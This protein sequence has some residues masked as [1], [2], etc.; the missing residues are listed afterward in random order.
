M[1]HERIRLLDSFRSL[2]ILSVMFYHFTFRWDQVLP[3]GNFYGNLGEYGWVG[4]QFFF[5]ISGFVISYTLENTPSPGR[6]FANRFIR[7][8]PPLLL[9]SLITFSVIRIFDNVPLFPLAHQPADLLPSLTLIGPPVFNHFTGSG[10]VFSWVDESYWSLWV[11]IQ[12]Y[13]IAAVVYYAA[14]ANFIR[15]LLWTAILFSSIT[16]VRPALLHLPWGI[17]GHP[18]LVPFVNQMG[19]LLNMF[20]ILYYINWFAMGAFFHYLYKGYRPLTRKDIDISFLIMIGFFLAD[21]TLSRNRQTPWILYPI[22]AAFFGLLIYK[23][24]WL[25]FLNL[26]ALQRLGVISYTVYLIHENCG[27]LLMSK[28][29]PYVNWNPLL[30]PVTMCLAILFAELSWRT[31]EKWAHRWLKRKVPVPA[32]LLSRNVLSPEIASPN[33]CRLKDFPLK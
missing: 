18:G 15:N 25:T 1:A 17:R 14:K 4:V 2:A 10:H 5:V 16:L 3:S 33:D 11:E 20:N 6:F 13:V 24:R 29:G 21:H 12:F 8:F 31:Y 19:E 30:A 7:L 27:V 32:E 9:C 23:P 28:V 26:P 22:I